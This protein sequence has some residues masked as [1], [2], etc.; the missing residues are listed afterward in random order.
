MLTSGD[1]QHSKRDRNI[2]AEKSFMVMN[3]EVIKLTGAFLITICFNS[4]GS[5]SK[6][7]CWFL[8][9]LLRIQLRIN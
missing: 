5:T 8:L 9:F 1:P 6:I 4:F 3:L 7:L 2:H